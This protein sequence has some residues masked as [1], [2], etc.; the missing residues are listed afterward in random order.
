MTRNTARRTGVRSRIAAAAARIMAEDGIDD[1]ALAKRKAARQ[2]GVGEGEGLPRNDEIEA[3]LHAYRALYQEEEHPEVLA[4]LRRIALEVMRHFERF[5]P[6]LT[7]PVLEG[8]AGP[9][10][11]IDVQ[12]F[13][14]STKDVEIFL[15]ERNVP[16]GTREGRRY[17]GGHRRAMSIFTLT[18][19]GIPVKLSVLDPRDERVALRTSQAGRVAPRAA[20]PE[21]AALLVR[22]AG[23]A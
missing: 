23:P 3:E 20:I 21:V 2:L 12:L 4:E 18:W 19:E 9:Y 6:Y 16:F 1:F 8:T 14:E 10:A 15:L 11:E 22:D 13:P 17:A 5:S 7:G